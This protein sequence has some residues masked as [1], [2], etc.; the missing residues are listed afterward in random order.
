[1]AKL[2]K[3]QLSILHRRERKLLARANDDDIVEI[4]KLH[5]SAMRLRKQA[6]EVIF[7]A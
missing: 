7:L 3:A 2:L 1:M 6:K 4:E 5:R